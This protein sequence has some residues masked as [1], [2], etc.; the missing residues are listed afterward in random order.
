MTTMTF[1]TQT[2][3]GV[4][5]PEVKH[6]LRGNAA[7]V[8]TPEWMV[9]I[10]DKLSSNV[11][12]FNDHAELYGFYGESGRATAES[13]GGELFTSATLKHSDVTIIIP[14]GFYAPVL[15][16]LMN[17]G[18][19]IALIKVVRLGHVTELKPLQTIEF[20]NCKI[21]N[22]RQ[23]LDKLVITFRIETR[24]HTNFQ[25]DQEGESKG[26]NVIDVDYTKNTIA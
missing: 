22:F 5:I 15:E 16:N 8:T 23:E 14:N 24:K 17:K 25:F 10:D 26:Q 11:D 6:D 7:K 12:G 19:T 20:G 2:P 21:Q 1:N 3:H 13:A 18:N 4:G 9:K